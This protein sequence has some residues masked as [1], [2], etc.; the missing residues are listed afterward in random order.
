[1]SL[2]FKGRHRLALFCLLFLSLTSCRLNLLAPYDNEL[3]LE[4][5][6]TAKEVDRF[7]LTMLEK[8]ESKGTT[9]AYKEFR[10]EYINIEVELNSLYNRNKIKPLNKYS[11]RNCEIA[12]DTWRRFK[13][14]HKKDNTIGDGL[15][16]YNRKFMN[17]LFYTIRIAEEAKK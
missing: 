1:M 14:E 11:T 3:S 16:Q 12:L 13:E 5:D 8:S 2:I 10:D 6:R 7:Y 17:D 15:I 9:R 4:I